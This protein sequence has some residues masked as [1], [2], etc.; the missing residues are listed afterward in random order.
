MS[1][2]LL[3]WVSLAIAALCLVRVRP[4]TFIFAGNQLGVLRA[5]ANIERFGQPRSQAFLPQSVF[6]LE[7]LAIARNLFLLSTLLLAVAALLPSSRRRGNPALLPALPRWLLLL[8]GAYFL[9]VIFSQGTIFSRSYSDPERQLY[10]L[11]LSGA[12]AFLCSVFVYEMVRRALIGQWSRLTTFALVLLLF[13][14]TDLLKGS[15]GL[16]TGFLV[17]AAFVL[18]GKEPVLWRRWAS[19]GAALLVLVG[20]S[21]AVRGVRATLF[22]EGAR[23]FEDLGDALREDEERVSRNAQGA[24]AFGNGVQ[25]AAHVLECVELYEAGVSREWRSVYLPALYTLQP[26]FI[27]NLLELTRQ[28]EAALELR[29]YFIH[30]GGIFLVGFCRFGGDVPAPAVWIFRPDGNGPGHISG[31]VMGMVLSKRF[32]FH[33]SESTVC[34]RH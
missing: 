20:L 8:L 7:N 27:M 26:K 5:L 33:R 29:D 22:S 17:F 30:G 31:F 14:L 9:A 28:K 10:G 21:L 24:E 2:D 19:L 4:A 25:Y 15:T 12:H 11:N 18:L 3:F 13:V 6:S 34:M 32:D 16:A 1:F 23:S